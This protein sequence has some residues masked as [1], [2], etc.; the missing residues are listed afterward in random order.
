MKYGTLVDGRPVPAPNPLRTSGSVTYN[1]PDA[2][3]MRE[4]YL[5]IVDTPMPETAED[6]EP[7]YYTS[8]WEEQDGQ[9]V[10]VW[11]ETEPPAEETAPAPEMTPAE[12]RE[13][14][15]DTEPCVVWGGDMLTVTQAAQQWSYYAAEGNAD[16]TD[17]LTALIGAAKQSIRGQYPDEEG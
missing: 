9:I 8:H 11:T 3:Y 13:R 12:Q 10:R 15:Y 17:A 1:P 2:L 4:G 7:V 5:P 6:A 16:K 14:A